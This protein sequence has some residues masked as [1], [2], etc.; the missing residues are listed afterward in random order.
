M[1]LRFLL[2]H[3]KNAAALGREGACFVLFVYAAQF[4]RMGTRQIK[5]NAATVHAITAPSPRRTQ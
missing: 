2:M 3:S 5:P 1:S 4:A